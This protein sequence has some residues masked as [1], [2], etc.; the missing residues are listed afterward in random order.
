MAPQNIIA[1]IFDF[2]DTLTDESTT[3][4]LE[5][6]G[7]DTKDFWRDQVQKQIDLGWDP[8][9]AYLSLML[10]V[11]GEGKPLGKLSNAK[12]REFGSKLEFYQGIPELFTELNE[13][14]K[15]HQIS[16]PSIDFFIGHL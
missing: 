3:R 12:L 7:V 11:T 8:S 15:V 6:Y 10:D 1:L 4:L 13:L 16:K 9:L 5:S 2:D 14:V